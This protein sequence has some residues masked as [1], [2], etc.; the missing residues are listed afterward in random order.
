M[1]YPQRVLGPLAFPDF[2]GELRVEVID[3]RFFGHHRGHQ[4]RVVKAQMQRARIVPCSFQAVKVMTIVKSTAITPIVLDSASPCMNRW[5]M[6]GTAV[7]P[8]KL[9]N[10]CMRAANK[11]T[12]PAI[13]PPKTK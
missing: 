4:I 1:G 9:T 7:G 10:T 12:A 13:I 8:T 2:D 5:T 3:P 11:P 6:T